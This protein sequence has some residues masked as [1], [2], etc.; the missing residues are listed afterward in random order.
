[1]TVD[2]RLFAAEANASIAAVCRALG[3]KRSTVYARENATLSA[4]ER[5]TVEL[6]AAIR[7]PCGGKGAG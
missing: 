3:L 4:R 6:D 5:D 2:V 7:G 1:M